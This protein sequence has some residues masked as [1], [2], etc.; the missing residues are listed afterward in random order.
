MKKEIAT[1]WVK[2]LRSGK[3]KQGQNHLCVLTS[4]GAE[5]CCLGVLT[6]MYQKDCKRKKIKPLPTKDNYSDY[7]E[8]CAVGYGSTNE[9]QV[10]HSKVKNW[11]G[12]KTKSGLIPNDDPEMDDIELTVM[13][14]DGDSFKKIA[15]FIEKNYKIL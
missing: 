7:R 5:H 14:D 10:L 6:D 11:A 13:N 1:R 9:F 12:M 3:Y 8:R 15:N 4:K 2:A